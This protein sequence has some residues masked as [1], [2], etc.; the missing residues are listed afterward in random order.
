VRKKGGRPYEP[1]T[2]REKP[3]Q[4]LATSQ[5]LKSSFFDIDSDESIGFS[6]IFFFLW[7]PRQYPLKFPFTIKMA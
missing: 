2:A 1:P 6:F 5:F 7:A 3:C 4:M